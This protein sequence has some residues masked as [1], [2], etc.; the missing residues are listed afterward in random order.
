MK[1]IKYL[2]YI[3]KALWTSL[4]L[5]MVIFLASCED[6]VDLD[7]VS[8]PPQVVVNGWLTNQPGDQ[9]IKLN[10]SASYFDNGTPKPVLGAA[11]TVTDNLGKV[12]E[13]KDLANNGLYIWKGGTTDTLGKIG[14]SYSLKIVNGQDTFTSFNE[15]KR[16]PTIDSIVYEKETL[17]YK[18][19]KGPKEGYI[20]SFYAK[21][22]DGIG[23]TYWIKP[24]VNGK[25]AVTK[26][27][28]LSI[29]YDAAFNAGAPSDGMIFMLPL[30]QSITTDSLYSPGASV[31]VELHSITNEA[32]EYI[33]QVAAQ[34]SN[35]GLF[36]TPITNVKSNV[37]NTNPN[38][39]RPLGYFGTSA[40]N[41][42]ETI[43][44]PEKARPD[45]K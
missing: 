6:V 8:G 16:V 27:A 43:V 15:I 26:A 1:N 5:V 34:A 18:P 2:I 22:F 35:G 9:T 37:I 10:W 44:D 13:F 36:A 39:I 21:D 19:D 14:R 31:G 45:K 12:F 25:V 41:R 42:M 20:V 4:S 38:G 30:R 28:Q 32:F 40:V 11:V 24:V 33:K 3:K 23:D 17:P 29:A 7:T